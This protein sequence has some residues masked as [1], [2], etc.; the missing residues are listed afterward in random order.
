MLI[1]S[2]NA[3][4]SVIIGLKVWPLGLTSSNEL[5]R[6]INETLG[7][8]LLLLTCLLLENMCHCL[9]LNAWACLQMFYS[10]LQKDSWFSL[11]PQQARYYRPD[12]MY[13]RKQSSHLSQWAPLE[14]TGKG[15]SKM[16]STSNL[17]ICCAPQPYLVDAE[18][19]SDAAE[20]KKNWKHKG[21][22]AGFKYWLKYLITHK[23][24][25]YMIQDGVFIVIIPSFHPMQCQL[26][27][28]YNLNRSAVHRKSKYRKC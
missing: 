20:P 10:I 9:P 17:T 4:H 12:L 16:F 28:R 21:N 6:S 25:L 5:I 13:W 3:V 24:C 2:V 15:I 14:N 11:P 23:K 1:L 8:V 19:S 22:S 18:Y 7:F 26:R 27:G